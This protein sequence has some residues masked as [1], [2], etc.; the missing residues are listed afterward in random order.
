MARK[1]LEPDLLKQGWNLM[2]AEHKL[3]QAK[4]DLRKAEADL[5]KAKVATGE[6][7]QGLE[8]A[9]KFHEEALQQLKGQMDEAITR[10]KSEAVSEFLK[11]E[12]Y[13]SRIEA[14][15]KMGRAQYKEKVRAV[16]VLKIVKRNMGVLEDTTDE[17]SEAEQNVNEGAEGQTVA[18]EAKDGTGEKGTEVN[19]EG[20]STKGAAG[21]E[22]DLN[23][24]KTVDHG[25]KTEVG[26]DASQPILERETDVENDVAPPTSQ[27]ETSVIDL[28]DL[29]GD[30]DFSGVL[31]D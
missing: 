15:F 3:W 17:E 11:F 1:N 27:K 7:G 24:V 23:T 8:Q 13:M 22:S 6:V 31:A 18:R 14:T 29:G 16:G 25:T 2:K 28:D 10:A 30:L 12:D 5:K 4:I 26:P 19:L 21:I 9:N 20:A